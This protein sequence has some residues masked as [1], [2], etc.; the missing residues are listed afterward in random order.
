MPGTG[1]PPPP[2]RLDTCSSQAR[3][4]ILM[5]NSPNIAQYAHRTALLNYM[6]A[7][8]HGYGFLVT[9]CPDVQDMGKDWAWDGN[10]EY[11]FVWSKARMLAHALRIFDI[12]LFIDS[13][14]FV[15]DTAVTI[16]SKVRELMDD[17]TC[18]VMADDCKSRSF[19]YNKDKVNAGVVLARRSPKTFEILDRWM[20][21]V[22]ECADWL[23]THPR[24]QACIDVLR[25]KS[26]PKEIRKVP[27]ETMNGSDGTWIRHYM[28]APTAQRDAV[29][30]ARLEDQLRLQMGACHGGDTATK[31]RRA[32]K[33]VRSL[34]LLLVVVSVACVGGYALARRRGRRLA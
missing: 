7:A 13:D 23:Y 26:Y 19:C 16:E 1:A 4:G 6:Y 17:D 11:L 10:N 30:S 34:L 24:E 9:R 25:Q 12:V 18:L 33:R 21:P 20:N 8:R 14:A 27:V 28:A 32:P 29:T 22:E 15:W 3:I 2:E 31:A 5:M